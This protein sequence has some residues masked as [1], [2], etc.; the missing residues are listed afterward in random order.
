MATFLL[1]IRTEEIPAQ[2]LAGARQQLEIGFAEG[3]DAAGLGQSEITVRSTSRRLVVSVQ[4]LPERQPDRRERL[5]GPPVSVAFDA[6]GAPTQAA[7]G[8]ARKAGVAVEALERVNTDRG[9]YLAADVVHPGR[10]TAEVLAELAGRVIPAL[11]FP[12]MMRW[13]EGEHLFVRPVHGVLAL[14]DGAT[15]KLELFGVTAGRTTVGHRVHAPEAFD[16]GDAESYAGDLE[17]RGVVVDQLRRHEILSSRARS[18]ADEVGCTVRPDPDLVAEHV[19][20]VEHPGLLRG[21]FDETFLDLPPEVVTTT[22]RHH[23]KC[24][25]LE[26]AGELAHYFLTVIDRRDD[27]DQLIRQGNEWV[28]GARLADARFFF[29]EDCKRPLAELLPKLARLEFHRALGSMADKATRVATLA[30]WMVDSAGLDLGGADLDQ[31]AG[32]VKVDLLTNMVGEFPELQGVMGGH[33][34]RRE[35][36]T[37]EL[38]TAARDHYQPQGFEGRLPASELGRLLAAADRLDTVAG[39]WAAGEI[40][41]GSKDPFG[42][43]RAA[44]GLVRIVAEAGWDLDL[45]A[46]VRRATEIVADGREVE[47]ETVLAGV[48]DFVAQRVRRYLVDLVGVAGDTADAVM[49]SSWTRLPDAAARARALDEARQAPEFRS[50]ALAFK[51]VRNITG[52]QPP[53]DLDEALLAE[54]AE[55]DLEHA[56]RDFHRRLGELIPRRQ[57]GEAFQAMVPLAEVLDRFFVEVLV[58]TEDERIRANR[59]ALLQSLGR[60][61]LTLADLS[62]LQ[63]EG[64]ES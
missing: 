22:L 42:M 16:L 40:P 37:E 59:I 31:S 43:R 23:Q 11:R 45:G 6:G 58:M 32:L 29:E 28:I 4:G 35:G 56:R 27:P 15:L 39:L 25:V 24:L 51:R 61:F 14:L 7:A 26:R 52:D 18:L 44:Q 46:A 19:E 8:F 60:D 55:R 62:R 36:A 49:A 54:A 30:R 33:Y 9:E 1:E 10:P 2:A 3:L 57:V 13:G 17:N 48:T 47:V 38:W 41:S 50:L 21:A 53:L 20:L 5:T 34:L 64:G 63:I 12:K